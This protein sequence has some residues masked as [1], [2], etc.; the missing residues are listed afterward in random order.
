MDNANAKKTKLNLVFT[1]TVLL[2][3]LLCACTNSIEMK[4]NDAN[5][6]PEKTIQLPGIDDFY[7]RDFMIESGRSDWLGEPV[8]IEDADWAV[9]F[10]SEGTGIK[11]DSGYEASIYGPANIIVSKYTLPSSIKKDEQFRYIA[12]LLTDGGK[13]G[14]DFMLFE[15]AMTTANNDFCDATYLANLYQP[16]E[17]PQWNNLESRYASYQSVLIVECRSLYVFS[18]V[19]DDGTYS[20]KGMSVGAGEYMLADW[21]AKF[22]R[23][24]FVVAPWEA[25]RYE[26][27]HWFYYD[28]RIEKY[29][30]LGLQIY[31][32]EEGIEYWEYKFQPMLSEKDKEMVARIYKA[33]PEDAEWFRVALYAKENLGEVFQIIY[34]NDCRLLFQ[35]INDDGWA[36]IYYNGKGE[37][38]EFWLRDAKDNQF[39]YHIKDL[40]IEAN[41]EPFEDAIIPADVKKTGIHLEKEYKAFLEHGMN[42]FHFIVKF[43]GYPAGDATTEIAYFSLEVKKEENGAYKDIIYLKTENYDKLRPFLLFEDVNFDE[44]LE[45]GVAHSDGRYMYYCWNEQREQLEYIDVEL[46]KF[47]RD[48]QYVLPESQVICQLIDDGAGYYQISIDK[49]FGNQLRTVRLCDYYPSEDGYNCVVY[50]FLNGK[51]ENK[52]LLYEGPSHEK[53]YFDVFVAGYIQTGDDLKK[54]QELENTTIFH[55]RNI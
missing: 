51:D 30:E 34:I 2:I 43:L 5:T 33:A 7:V 55:D 39:T 13:S 22:A 16:T 4:N 9:L 50:D 20:A 52:E 17:T 1:W 23:E 54:I 26:D 24:G 6:V 40:C 25:D 3:C 11:N 31:E 35:D 53:V 19:N 18:S 27:T 42:E 15:D 48:P 44:V 12:D 45:I 36:D 21:Q 37:P 10:Q 46:D 41:R 8:N 38:G 29:P 49:W 14:L 47:N 32:N 28:Q